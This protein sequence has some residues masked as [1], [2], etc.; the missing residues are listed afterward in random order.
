MVFDG[1]LVTGAGVSA[2]LDLGLALIG[3]LRGQPFAES[4]QLMAEY[5]PAPPYHAGTPGRAPKAIEQSVRGM[6][7]PLLVE[8]EALAATRS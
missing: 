8:T 4:V 1:K 6:F 5:A 3:L 2:G 7:A